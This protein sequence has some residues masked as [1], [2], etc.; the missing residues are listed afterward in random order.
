MLDPTQH[1]IYLS[2]SLFLSLSL[3]LSLTHTHSHTLSL[4]FLQGI[5]ETLPITE[6]APRLI[7]NLK[8]LGYKVTARS[9]T[10]I[11][12]FWIFGGYMTR[13]A[14]HKYEERWPCNHTVEYEHFVSPSFGWIRD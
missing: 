3:S 14:P 6:G 2:R 13:F 9:S 10:Y 11:S 7:T 8:R 4:S 5:A 12:F 1:S